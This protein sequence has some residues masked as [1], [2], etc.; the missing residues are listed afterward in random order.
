MHAIGGYSFGVLCLID[1]QRQH[2]VLAEE[3]K[4]CLPHRK[5]EYFGDLYDNVYPRVVW[6]KGRKYANT[7]VLFFLNLMDSELNTCDE[8]FL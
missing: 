4:A 1:P 7:Y 5:D 2:R 8:L 6:W 3:K